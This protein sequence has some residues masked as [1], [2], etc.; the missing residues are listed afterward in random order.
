MVWTGTNIWSTLKINLDII[1]FP[2]HLKYHLNFGS[3]NLVTFKY[4][5]GKIGN[6][7]EVPGSSIWLDSSVGDMFLAL[8]ANYVGSTN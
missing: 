2:N 8:Q 4:Y 5:F 6:F 1:S 3:E 7:L